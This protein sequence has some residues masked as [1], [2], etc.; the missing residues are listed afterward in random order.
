M[1]TNILCFLLTEIKDDANR[2]SRGVRRWQAWGK[3]GVELWNK[4][5]IILHQRISNALRPTD[6]KAHLLLFNNGN[7][8]LVFNVTLSITP[9]FY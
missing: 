2:M 6:K 5:T 8:N 4:Y 3:R 9:N 1:K 7:A